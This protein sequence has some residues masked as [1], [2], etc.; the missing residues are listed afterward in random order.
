MKNAIPSLIISVTF[1]LTASCLNDKQKLELYP[2]LTTYNVS[3]SVFFD[4]A[5]F[6]ADKKLVVASKSLFLF[7]LPFMEII[8]PHELP[9]L[10]YISVEDKDE[11]IAYLQKHNFK[12][13][14]IHDPKAEFFRGNKILERLKMEPDNTVVALFMEGNEIREKAQVGMRD[15]LKEQVEKFVNE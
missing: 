15:I 1:L 12:Y 9:V 13:P 11:I 6:E 8:E 7:S 2:D 4:P 3:D 10:I 5:W 14:F